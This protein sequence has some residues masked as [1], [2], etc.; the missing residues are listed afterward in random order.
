MAKSKSGT[1]KKKGNKALTEQKLKFFPPGRV[2]ELIFYSVIMFTL[3]VLTGRGTAPITFDLNNEKALKDLTVKE[4]KFKPV[5]V[6]IDFYRELSREGEIKIDEDLVKKTEK[7][8]VKT[9]N[10]K[11][12]RKH[13]KLY[14]IDS[15]E[16]TE[17][18]IKNIEVLKKQS[19][20]EKRDFLPKVFFTI[21]V[22]ALKENRDAAEL[23]GKLKKEGFPAYNISGKS[24]DGSLWHRVRIGK[25]SQ[26]EEAEKMKQELLKKLNINGLLLK[27]NKQE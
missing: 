15:A 11:G 25:F 2:A 26:K 27:V 12:E 13:S 14:E 1:K 4:K 6:K 3:G 16:K 10:I 19:E 21:Q 17:K 24:D 9:P 18:R 23:A 7:L 22:A 20:P 5:K 8:P